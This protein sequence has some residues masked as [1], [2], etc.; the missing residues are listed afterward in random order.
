[1]DINTKK[2]KMYTSMYNKILELEQ[3]YDNGFNL[4]KM[5]ANICRTRILK[6]QKQ[7]DIEY[8]ELVAIETIILSTFIGLNREKLELANSQTEKRNLFQ[9]KDYES[10]TKIFLNEIDYKEGFEVSKIIC[11]NI[12]FNPSQQGQFPYMLE[13]IQDDNKNRPYDYISK[14]RN[15]LLHA[16]YY[17]ETPDILHIQ[18]HDE[19]GNLT[20]EAKMLMFS[21]ANFVIDFF[22]TLGVNSSFALYDMP[23]IEKF[24]T[25][26]DL[27]KYL[28]EYTYT[29]I[30]FNKIPE[31]YKFTGSNALYARLNG[32]FGLDS[33]EQKDI[34]QELLSLQKEGFDFECTERKL[35]TDE[36][37]NMFD[38]ITRNYK[39]IY[40][41]PE[42]VPH[43]S[44]L[45]K[46]HL[47]PSHEITN[48]I[49][50]V[51][52]YIS[53]KKD[54]LTNNTISS[55]KIL[56]ELKYDEYCDVAFK[57]ALTFLKANVIN[58]AIECSE[59]ENIDFNKVDTHKI[60]INDESEFNR[61]KAIYIANGMN[62]CEATNK[63]KLETVRNALAHGG[64]R[65]N[66]NI[67]PGLGIE[68]IDI[69]HNVSPLSVNTSLKHLNNVLSSEIF[70]P[71][72]IKV[73]EKSKVLVKK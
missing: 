52:T 48:C 20:F 19:N 42:I 60:K 35:N 15:A 8:E 47:C 17:L 44:A 32:C 59:F 67:K 28:C 29:D 37:V 45:L 69:Y 56:D 21:F 23:N 64:K 58:Y 71:E 3:F 70:K 6:N 16:E 30:K 9:Y 57:Y 18:N 63:L 7:K 68:L 34:L 54:F 22:G 12:N 38:F 65:I 1:M 39:N 53:S 31:S 61:R 2:L 55:H 49:G 27:V 72:N 13:I 43:I 5:K 73:K 11:R 51:M 25:K 46:L 33:N 41:N 50:N 26:E 14:I 62:E 4:D 40:N 36:I 24:K 66:V 10:D